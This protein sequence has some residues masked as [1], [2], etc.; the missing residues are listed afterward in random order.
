MRFPGQYQDKETNLAYNA[1][2]DYDAVVA[3][4]LESDPTGIRA[5]LNTYIYVEADPLGSTDLLGLRRGGGNSNPNYTVCGYYRQIGGQY[6]CKYH[7][8]AYG[9]CMG[10]DTVVNALTALI[11]TSQLNCIRVCL[12]EAD[13]AARQAPN[14]RAKCPFG[15]CTKRSCIDS[16]H[17]QCFTQCNALGGG[18]FYGGN[19]GNFP[20]D[21]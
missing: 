4:Y 5:G 16:Y 18:F 20:N 15:N 13:K 1:M 11:T 8:F 10:Q 17:N 2:R 12:V 14:C 21:D 9:V 6:G 19:Y 7:T 3:R